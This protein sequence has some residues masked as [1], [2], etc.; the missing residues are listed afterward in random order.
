MLSD[1]EIKHG[2][3][4]T[5]CYQGVIVSV[6]GVQKI[7]QTKEQSAILTKSKQEDVA[8]GDL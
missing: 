4:T 6:M 5:V 8:F 2:K 7:I 1:G 3:G